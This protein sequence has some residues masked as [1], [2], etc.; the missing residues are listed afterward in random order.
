MYAFKRLSKVREIT[1]RWIQEYNEERPHDSLGD[2]N[3]QEY[4][5]AYEQLENS[6]W[7]RN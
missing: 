4:L 6:N 3:P 7:L 1:D 5:V 2:L